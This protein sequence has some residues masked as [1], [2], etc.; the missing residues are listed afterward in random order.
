MAYPGRNSDSTDYAP[1]AYSKKV[2]NGFA[3]TRLMLLMAL[4]DGTNS[5]VRHLRT[6]AAE[7][8]AGNVYPWKLFD[9]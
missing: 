9:R 3:Y 5:K 6:S 8:H 2:I 7:T 4:I 1:D